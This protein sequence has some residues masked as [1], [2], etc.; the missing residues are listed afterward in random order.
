MQIPYKGWV[1]D[2]ASVKNRVNNFLD[3]SNLGES[4]MYFAIAV[5]GA[6]V[7]AWEL[8]VR[9]PELAR[10]GRFHLTYSN[11]I[12]QQR[13]PIKGGFTCSIQGDPACYPPNFNYTPLDHDQRETLNTGFTAKLA[14][15]SWLSTNV[16]YGSGFSNGL[17]CADPSSCPANNGP[18][19]GHYLPVHT[20]FDLSAG[21][22]FNGRW[23]LSAS[24]LNA[25][26][27]RVL[28]DNSITIGG[29]HYNDPR[30]ISAQLRYRFHF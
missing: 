27:H 6:L 23:K 30:L 29:F 1:L 18:Y 13:G 26:N 11:Q 5:D 19:G 10:I 15:Q 24:L 21:H 14:R 17:A 28:L 8:T 12:A 20:T 25:A 7:R 9:S 22:N 4:N 16:Y 2:V 3:H